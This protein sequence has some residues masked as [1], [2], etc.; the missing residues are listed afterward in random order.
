MNIELR[1]RLEAFEKLKKTWS[2]EHRRLYEVA[3]E[4]IA[5]FYLYGSHKAE[6]SIAQVD[7]DPTHLEDATY[8]AESAAVNFCVKL[9]V[10]AYNVEAYEGRRCV[11]VI[12][13]DIDRA[14]RKLAGM[15]AYMHYQGVSSYP[16]GYSK[17]D[18]VTDLLEV[19][20]VGRS[21]LERRGVTPPMEKPKALVDDAN[22][23][24]D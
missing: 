9:G 19:Y 13:S 18:A 20:D 7:D 1:D 3:G 12:G 17:E 4:L 14:V 24:V 8:K 10:F 23:S 16:V 5:L 11:A 22:V 15:W 2:P 21:A 6:I